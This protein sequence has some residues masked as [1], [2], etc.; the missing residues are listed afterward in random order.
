[1]RK[2]TRTWAYIKKVTTTTHQMMMMTSTQKMKT[3]S[4]SSPNYRL[5][6]LALR[7]LSEMFLLRPQKMNYE[8]CKYFGLLSPCFPSLKVTIFRYLDSVPSGLCDM[9]ASPW[10]LPQDVHAA[11]FLRVSGI[12]QTRIKWQT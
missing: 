11:L 12:R 6:R 3:R 10:I 5:P 9:P 1:M 7:Y 8:L 2:A 4:R